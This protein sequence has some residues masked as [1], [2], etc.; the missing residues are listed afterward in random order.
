MGIINAKL[1]IL[2]KV[3]NT[4]DKDK[5]VKY[6]SISNTITEQKVLNTNIQKYI[7]DNTNIHKSSLS[8]ELNVYRFFSTQSDNTTGDS[9]AYSKTHDLPAVDNHTM[10]FSIDGG[11]EFNRIIDLDVRSSNIYTRFKGGGEWQPWIKL[12]DSNNYTDYAAA[13][14]H[15]HDYIPLSGTKSLTGHI[16]PTTWCTINLGSSDYP[17]G[18]IYAWNGVFLDPTKGKADTAGIQILGT[19][20]FNNR[21]GIIFGASSSKHIAL[22]APL[23]S[24][25]DD[26]D[27]SYVYLPYKSGTI[28]RLEDINITITDWNTATTSGFYV[29]ATGASNAPVSD[30]GITG[31]VSATGNMIVQLVYPESNDD[32]ELI[33]YTR[34][35]IKNNDTIIWTKWIKNIALLKTYIIK[36]YGAPDNLFNQLI[37]DTVK[38]IIFTDISMPSNATLIDV[39]DD[40]VVAWVDTSD[41]TKMYVSTQY[42]GIKVEGNINISSM[43]YYRTKLTSLDL[44]NFDTSNVKDMGSMFFGCNA[45]TKLDL[46]NFDTSNVTNMSYMFYACMNL[47]TL[48]LSNFNTSKVTNMG[49]MF[50]N[51]ISLTSLDLSNFDTSN[52]T[53]MSNMFNECNSL[54]TIK[55]GNKF[56]WGGTLFNLR[57]SDT[58]KDETGKQYTSAD[59]FPSNVAHTYT[60]VS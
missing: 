26:A 45:L 3:D 25:L 40:G 29:S 22:V 34:K 53:N 23:Q 54:N 12:L 33:S 9:D 8:E 27:Y 7:D 28:A 20:A 48:D 4:P 5:N 59:T 16:V 11:N 58:W 39:D 46:S 50:T 1:R 60:R 2:D 38:S 55:V 14:D 15:T 37:P 44:S 52:V 21:C 43:F 36:G 32:T 49:D 19:P 17:F 57:L 24:Q 13:K 18:T 47:N 42:A 56:K 41:N 35:G 6:S 10:V 31:N 30:V 51:C